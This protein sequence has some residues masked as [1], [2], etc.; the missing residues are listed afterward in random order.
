MA[1]IDEEIGVVSEAL[2]TFLG[3]I[4]DVAEKI[5]SM[6]ETNKDVK[7]LQQKIR[8]AASQQQIEK[9]KERLDELQE[10]HL[11]AG[12]ELKVFWIDVRQ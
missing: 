2:K 11:A 7:R 6:E 3:R 8:S 5:H 1:S 12:E 9:D 4:Q 10:S